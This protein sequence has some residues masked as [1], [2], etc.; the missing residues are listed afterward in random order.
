MRRMM[1][2][3][4]I[5]FTATMS[6][7]RPASAGSMTY[8]SL[9]DSVAFGETTFQNNPSAGNRGYAKMYNEYLGSQNGGVNPKLVNLAI[10]GETSNSF[11]TASGRV[12]PVAGITDQ[13]LAG[14]NTHYTNTPNES[15]NIKF[16]QVIGN[17]LAQ[18]NTISNITV[19]LGGN[20]LFALASA[21]GFQGSTPASQQMQLTA[22]LGTFASNYTSLLGEI[23]ALVPNA[24]V[25]L[26]GEYNPF[27]ATPN[28]PYAPFAAPAIQA[29]NAVIKGLA[30]QS[31]ATYVDTYTPFV[32]KESALTYITAIPGDVH[33]NAAGYAAITGQL[34]AVPEPSTLA[35]LGLGLAAIAVKARRR[36][37]V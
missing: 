20:D 35:I 7:A 34:E 31:G 8:V 3:A 23:K 28:S 18:G 1:V 6:L 17:Q 16:F 12:P 9:G 32:G 24:K 36:R 4:M 13:M 21:P 22:A 27:P 37:T 5:A 2:A 25:S 29:L 11:S 26:L 10:D 15:Q 19:S 14:Y 33:P 30:Q